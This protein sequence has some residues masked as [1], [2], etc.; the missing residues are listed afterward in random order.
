MIL[1]VAIVSL[2]LASRLVRPIKAMAMATR[3]LAS[4][5]YS[6]RVPISSSDELGQ[7]ARDFNTMALTLERNEKA[8][9]EWVADIS[10]E[11]RTPISVLRGELEALLEG[12]RST[13]PESIRSLHAEALR[14]QRL[15][16]DLYQLS[17]SDIGALS[18]R[19]KDLDLVKVLQDAIEA[20]RPEFARKGISIREDIADKIQFAVFADMER[21]RQLFGN[22]L[23][24]SVKYTDESGEL[25]V[26]LTCRDN[27]A[28]IEFQDSAPGVENKNLDKLFDKFYRVDTSRSRSSGG[29]GLGLAICKNIVDAHE[30]SITA[31]PSPLDGV[32]IRVIIPLSGRCS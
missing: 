32:L 2:P 1:F 25:L 23:D 10:H 19:K 17:V 18:Y 31:H 7:L 22:L 12:I 3:D 6:I 9:R 13:T 11:L 24:N 5:R 30:G 15:V 28:V 26:S 29:A 14:L 16:D 27:R 4:G 21:I 20:H 8:R